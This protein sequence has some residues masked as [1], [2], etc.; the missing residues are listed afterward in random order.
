MRQ[1]GRLPPANLGCLSYRKGIFPV[2]SKDNH[3]NH[4][5]IMVLN[6][7]YLELLPKK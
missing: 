6:N 4:S 3:K 7:T 1:L 2:K 5:L